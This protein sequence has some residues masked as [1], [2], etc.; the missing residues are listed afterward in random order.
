MPPFT[1]LAGLTAILCLLFT[2][3]CVA[4]QNPPPFGGESPAAAPAVLVPEP[5]VEKRMPDTGLPHTDLPSPERL[6]VRD[7]DLTIVVRDV[8]QTIADLSRMATE[9]GGFVVSSEINRLPRGLQGQI[10]LWVEAKRLNEALDRVHKLAIEVR[11]ENISGQDVTA[12]YVDLEARLRNLEVAEQQLQRLMDRASNTDEV[13][14]VYRELVSVR[15]QIE[16]LRGRMNYLKEATSLS[17]INAAILQDEL[18]RPIEVGGWQFVGEVRNAVEALIQALQ[19]LLR[20][21]IWLVIV[22]APTLSLIALPFAGLA[23]LVR[24]R[25][26]RRARSVSALPPNV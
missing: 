9:M 8:E 25:L 26:S 18:A 13:L 24:R 4:Q 19:F 12:E 22:V 5:A 17:R 3:G 6:V 16:Q 2:T 1:R 10:T 23:W 7:A 20:A 21:A 14:N 15:S 11:S